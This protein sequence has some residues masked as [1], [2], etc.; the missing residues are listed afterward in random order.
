[1]K[2]I[3]EMW[4]CFQALFNLFPADFGIQIDLSTEWRSSIRCH[5][6]LPHV[7]LIASRVGG[8]RHAASSFQHSTCCPSEL[9]NSGDG[10]GNYGP[11]AYQSSKESLC[12]LLKNIQNCFWLHFMTLCFSWEARIPECCEM[13]RLCAFM[14]NYVLCNLV[15]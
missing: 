7:G 6:F 2:I 3:H 12:F 11:A 8:S 15:Q 10:S 1:M 9:L 14:L 5:V 13:E 4:L